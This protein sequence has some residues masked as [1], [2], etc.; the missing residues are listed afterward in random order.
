MSFE[1]EFAELE[2]ITKKFE[3]GGVALEEGMHLYEKGVEHL[4][5]CLADMGEKKGKLTV[6]K[7]QADKLIKEVVE[8]CE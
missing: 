2:K 4:K 3:E 8:M 7:K 6:L 1:K 5:N